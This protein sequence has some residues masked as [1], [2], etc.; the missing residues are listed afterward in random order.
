MVN[1]QVHCVLFNSTN[2]HWLSDWLQQSKT[3]S[4]R[5]SVYHRDKKKTGELFIIFIKMIKE[6]QLEL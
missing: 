2:I 1:Y 5:S 6:F 4:F 3:K